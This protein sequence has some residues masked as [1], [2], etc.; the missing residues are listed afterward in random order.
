MKPANTRLK[1]TWAALVIFTALAGTAIFKG[2]EGVAT[3]CAAGILTIVTGYQASRAYTK[4][5]AI[6]DANTQSPAE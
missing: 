3:T 2:M 4:T 5:A 1:L 6:K